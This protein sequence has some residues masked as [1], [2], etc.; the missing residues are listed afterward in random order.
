MRRPSEP[1]STLQK[2]HFLVLEGLTPVRSCLLDALAIA[3]L[4]LLDSQWGGCV[5]SET[6]LGVLT[7]KV[8]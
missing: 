4:P 3:W 5:Y 2:A 1:F 6:L 8:M 7:M